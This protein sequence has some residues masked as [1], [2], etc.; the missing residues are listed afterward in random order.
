[1]QNREGERGGGER[2]RERG[3][4]REGGR[5][6]PLIVQRTR[7]SVQFSALRFSAL[8]FSALRFSAV[9]GAVLLIMRTKRL[10]Q[11]G[12]VGEDQRFVFR[13]SGHHFTRETWSGP[14]STLAFVL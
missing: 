13:R 11:R 3:G 6:V 12:N 5:S 4:G 1:M 7:S 14:V 9:R 10:E 2:E 8:R